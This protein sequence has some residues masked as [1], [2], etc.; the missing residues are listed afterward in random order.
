MPP[1]R[2]V[3]S[4]SRKSTPLS[5]PRASSTNVPVDTPTPNKRATRSSSRN[6]TAAHQ[7]PRSIDE[8]LA[9]VH[10]GYESQRDD[11]L[12]DRNPP[13]RELS[14]DGSDLESMLNNLDLDA[15]VDNI[16]LLHDD[17]RDLLSLFERH[18]TAGLHTLV[19]KLS[20]IN[21]SERKR[22]RIRE[23]RFET[24]REPYVE[25]NYIKPSI[26]V[27]SLAA[28]DPD[29]DIHG[30]WRPDPVLYL[31]NLASQMVAV[32][33]T[34]PEHRSDYLQYMFNNFPLPFTDM[35]LFAIE[36]P[37]LDQTVDL[38]LDILTQFFIYRA[39]ADQ[40]RVEFDPD[41]LARQVFWTDEGALRVFVH[42]STL[43][44]TTERLQALRKHFSLDPQQPVDIH[45]LEEQFSWPGFVVEVTKWTMSRKQDL[46]QFISSIGGIDTIADFLSA[47]F[48]AD[49]QQIKEG[50]HD[51][52]DVGAEHRVEQRAV[53][54]NLGPASN[55]QDSPAGPPTGSKLS[56][57]L[58]RF[59]T[60]KATYAAKASGADISLAMVTEVESIRETPQSPTPVENDDDGM[61]DEDQASAQYPHTS[62]AGGQTDN[63]DSHSDDD[64]ELVRQRIEFFRTARRQQEQS[65]KENKKMAAKK[66]SL[67]DRQED[68]ERVSFSEAPEE[69]YPAPQ[70]HKR[71]RLDSEP[72]EE[73]EDAFEI[74]QR[75]AKKRRVDDV[76]DRQRSVAVSDAGRRI[77]GEPP[78]TEADPVVDSDDDYVNNDDEDDDDAENEPQVIPATQR[79]TPRSTL[80]MQA[81]RAAQQG[82]TQRRPPPSTAPQPRPPPTSTQQSSHTLNR[83]PLG[84]VIGSRPPASSAP[85][86]RHRAAPAEAPARRVSPPRRNDPYDPEPPRSQIAQ[87]N[88]EAKLA[89]RLSREFR[90]PK[91][92]VRRGYTDEEV[93]RLMEMVALYGTSWATILKEDQFH[94]DGPRLQGRGQVQLKDK[95]RNIKMD[96]LKYVF[97]PPPMSTLAPSINPLESTLRGI[98]SV[99]LISDV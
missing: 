88:R 22:L 45:T 23:R 94:P 2:A 84:T 72:S 92:Q 17:A 63:G 62:Q 16:N 46:D 54:P 20:Q 86:P 60:L 59:N 99:F 70:P 28:R 56:S 61:M 68:A 93:E 26:V 74:D 90:C 38:S 37:M 87:V 58:N 25:S 3:R 73:E 4:V 13:S 71:Q 80:A 12:G 36:E 14:T 41:A 43:D 64:S 19:A 83:A 18:D 53:D 42:D 35:D 7:Q 39:K 47:K 6:V 9:T 1:R 79:W 96:F 21:S 85:N 66:P 91:V 49:S 44:K 30:P 69:D 8:V 95:A 15:I 82:L 51:E 89:T 57:R 81:A 67:L 31:A 78:I 27:G 24:S 52:P 10:E 76:Q 77:R 48:L 34:N 75:A 40:K 11:E 97:F 5:P 55:R 50:A 32:L 33:S 29:G 65:E 98:C